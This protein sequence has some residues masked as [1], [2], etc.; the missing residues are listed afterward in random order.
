M[1]VCFQSI[2][3]IIWSLILMILSLMSKV[4]KLEWNL[5]TQY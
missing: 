3:K 1:K 4:L 5:Q 2:K